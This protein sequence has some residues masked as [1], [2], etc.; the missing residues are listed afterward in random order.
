MTVYDYYANQSYY[1]GYSMM[2]T[3]FQ[4][5][6]ISTLPPLSSGD[7]PKS[8][9]SA[10]LYKFANST[11]TWLV[12]WWYATDVPYPV[13]HNGATYLNGTKPC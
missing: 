2:R 8:G 7:R 9:N 3:W 1:T 13:T 5:P 10:Y 11:N 12:G 4:W 6:L